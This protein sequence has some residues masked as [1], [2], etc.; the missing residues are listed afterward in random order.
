LL[1]PGGGGGGISSMYAPQNQ[2]Q[3]FLPSQLFDM[4]QSLYSGKR[5]TGKN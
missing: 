3:G 2:K 5:S 1:Q 4:D